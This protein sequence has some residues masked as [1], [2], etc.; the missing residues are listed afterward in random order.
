MLTLKHR[1]VVDSRE[2]GGNTPVADQPYLEGLAILEQLGAKDE[3][4]R[5]GFKRNDDGK[6]VVEEGTVGKDFA[7]SVRVYTEV[8]FT[9]RPPSGWPR[10]GNLWK[11]RLRGRVRASA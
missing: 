2:E 8:T 7:G 1:E 4:V 9:A 11:R 6:A 3:A 5:G 10:C